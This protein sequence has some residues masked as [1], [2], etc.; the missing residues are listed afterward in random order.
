[1]LTG[2]ISPGV[3]HLRDPRSRVYNFDPYLGSIM[4]VTEF[5]FDALKKYV[6]SSKDETLRQ[7]ALKE[8]KKYVGSSS[9]MTSVLSHF[10]YL[11]SAWRGV[12]IDNL[13]QGFPDRK[14]VV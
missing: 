9:S 4:P 11:L 12:N 10:H 5:D 6:T 14:S 1:M 3:Y 8:G 2:F 7:I 13:S